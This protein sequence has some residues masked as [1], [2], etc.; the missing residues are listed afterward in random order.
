MSSLMTGDCGIS[1]VSTYEL[2]TGLIKCGNA[3]VELPKI[4]TL[5]AEVRELAFDSAAS[6]EAAKIRVALEA[7][8]QIIGPYDLLIAGHA[9][10]LNLILVTNNTKEFIRVRGLRLEDWQL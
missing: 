5:L 10:A 3:A 1:A 7:A 9:L 4:Q 6:F 2:F 8:G